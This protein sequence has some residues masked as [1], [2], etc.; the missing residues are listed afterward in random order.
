LDHPLHRCWHETISSHGTLSC[1]LLC[2]VHEFLILS[3]ART[4]HLWRLWRQGQQEGHCRESR[5]C[6]LVYAGSAGTAVFAEFCVSRNSHPCHR[7]WFGC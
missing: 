4:R 1:F 2:E 6:H 5:V 7:A 3:R